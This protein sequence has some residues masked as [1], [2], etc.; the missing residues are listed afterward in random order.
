M[1]VQGVVESILVD[2]GRRA[3]PTGKV[4]KSGRNNIRYS[5]RR[6]P[7]PPGSVCNEASRSQSL[8]IVRPVT[9]RAYKSYRTFLLGLL[10]GLSRV[11]VFT[12]DTVNPQ[13]AYPFRDIE[14]MPR[15]DR[16]I[17]TYSNTTI[18]VS[19]KEHFR[20]TESPCE[21]IRELIMQFRSIDFRETASMD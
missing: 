5:S 17:R 16:R 18:T 10:S 20:V 13:D 9:V 11:L 8:A 3:A 7:R 6:E 12:V 15:I 19:H 14:R 4:R 2:S 21:W 1:I